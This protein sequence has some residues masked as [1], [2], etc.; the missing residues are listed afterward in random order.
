MLI[1]LETETL[2]PSQNAVVLSIGAIA[3]SHEKGIEPIKFYSKI[4]LKEQDSRIIDPQ[5]VAGWMRRAQENDEALE[6]FDGARE[7]VCMALERLSCYIN[8]HLTVDGEVW[9]EGPDFDC[10]I[11]RSLYEEFGIG[12]PWRASQQRCVRTLRNLVKQLAVEI[13]VDLPWEAQADKT[14]SKVEWDARFIVASIDNLRA[15]RHK[16]QSSAWV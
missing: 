3:F 1:M 2:S 12:V 7:S 13:N 14:L 9:S 5:F 4:D 16:S 10:A 11:V 15:R 6:I 8:A